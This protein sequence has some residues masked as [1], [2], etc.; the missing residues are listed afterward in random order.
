MKREIFSYYLDVNFPYDMLLQGPPKY[1]FGHSNDVPV[2]FGWSNYDLVWKIIY[3]RTTP[4]PW[5]HDLDTA[6]RKNYLN[7]VYQNGTIY[8]FHWWPFLIENRHMLQFTSEMN[9]TTGKI[10]LVERNVD[11]RNEILRWW[12]EDFESG[13]TAL[14]T[15]VLLLLINLQ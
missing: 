9:K 10:E 3:C 4:D 12:T 6:Y 15:S 14:Q 1:G 11:N 5:I 13:S 7:Q 2:T 8:R